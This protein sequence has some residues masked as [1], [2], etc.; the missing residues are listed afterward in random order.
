MKVVVVAGAA[1]GVGKTTV[2]CGLLRN[3]PG[4][5]AI[6]VTRCRPG[7]PCPHRAGCDVCSTLD[8]PY[9]LAEMTDANDAKGK[10][11][12]RMRRAGAS[13]VAWLI[14]RPG[15]LEEGFNAALRG[16]SAAPGVVVEGNSAAALPGVDFVVMILREGMADRSPGA[17]EAE[18]RADVRIVL[19][20][21]GD[22]VEI[23]RA[24]RGIAES[25]L[26]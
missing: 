19:T 9:R 13:R 21:A 3:L 15:A 25:L 20:G 16:L 17:D 4:W 22:E 2:A 10:D 5:A 24:C 8:E 23:E 1:S 18:A 26:K 6:K 12:W 7:R 11:T 14:A